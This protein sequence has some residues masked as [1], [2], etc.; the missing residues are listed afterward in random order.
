MKEKQEIQHIFLIADLSG[1]TALTEAH[2]SISAARIIKRYIEIVRECLLEDSRLVET[3]GDEVLI[4]GNDASHIIQAGIN[5]RKKVENEPNFPAV[6]IGIH[7]GDVLEQ[8][9]RFFGSAINIAS[10]TAAYARAGQI[11]ATAAAIKRVADK[12]AIS[13]QPLGEIQFKNIAESISIFEIDSGQ[14]VLNMNVT[15][16]VCRMQ[17]KPD[18]ALG[19]LNYQDQ[20][21]FFC[22]FE[23]A[24]AFASHPERYRK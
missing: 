8:D 17:L 4:I 15:D 10:R 6:H 18:T 20:N 24:R 3:V 5:L 9:G 21:Y 1:Y 14:S 19:R 13:Y 7:A 23:C 12:K 11:I 22:S 2:G 16:P